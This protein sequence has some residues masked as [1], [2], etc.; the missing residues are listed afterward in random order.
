MQTEQAQR[1][2]SS[3]IRSNTVGDDAFWLDRLVSRQPLQQHQSRPLISPALD[4]EVH[5]LALIVDRA[6]KK[7]P[8]STD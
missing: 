2:K 7:H 4:N 1:L 6:P 5:D 8:L 3:W